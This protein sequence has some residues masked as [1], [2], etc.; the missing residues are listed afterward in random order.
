MGQNAKLA[1]VL[2][3][4]STA[5]DYIGPAYERA[6]AMFGAGAYLHWYERYGCERGDFEQA[7]AS[8]RDIIRTYEEF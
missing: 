8:V 2:A 3:N 1:T 4:S 7:F 6:E 5:L